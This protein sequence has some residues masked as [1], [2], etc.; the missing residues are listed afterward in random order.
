MIF[1]FL[2]FFPKKEYANTFVRGS[3]HAN[4][5]RYFKQIDSH[6]GRGDRYEG[7][8]TPELEGLCLTLTATDAQTGEIAEYTIPIEDF[9]SPPIMQPRWFDPINLFCMYAGHSGSIKKVSADNL[10]SFKKQLEIPEDC[11]KFGKYAVLIKN[12]KEF[13]R[14]VRVAA[15]RENYRINWKLVRYYDPEVG[16]P[17][18]ESN[19]DS[20]FIKRKKYEYQK[21][22]RLAI[23]TGTPGC[24]PIT[25]DIGKIDDIAVCMDSGEIN[26]QID[27]KVK[28]P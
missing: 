7:A 12:P 1:F 24:N 23:D 20:I 4:R 18:L 8:I 22:F 14:R 25:L 28:R 13:I 17:P 6:D 9:A 11:T 27:I 10:A 16:T 26:R 19:F 5:L 3:L 21:E 15:E 2:K